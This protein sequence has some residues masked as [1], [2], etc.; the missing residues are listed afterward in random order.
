MGGL[1][2]PDQVVLIGAISLTH[3]SDR[4]LTGVRSLP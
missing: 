1:A 2:S 4:W 3:L